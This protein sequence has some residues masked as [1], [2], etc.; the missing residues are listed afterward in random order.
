V[1]STY[2]IN[3]VSKRSGFTPATL[4]YYEELGLLPAPSRT[5]AGYRLYDDRALERLAFIARAKQLGCS[6]DETADLV[7][8]WEGGECGPIQDRLRSLVAEKLSAAQTQIVE[9]MTL[10]TELQTAAAALEGHRPQGPCDDECGCETVSVDDGGRRPVM[11]STKPA[12]VAVVAPIECSLTANS[13]RRQLDDWNALFGWNGE[14]RK[15]VATR[16]GVNGGVRLEF[17]PGIDVRELARLATAEQECCRFFSFNLT[18]DHRGTGLEVRA[19]ADGMA[20]L[21]ALF[22]AST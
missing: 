18:V 7:V 16:V 1:T 3:E 21:H 15:Q 20:V 19:P 8:A 2:K 22:G 12:K 9:L 10:T 4:R 13:M 17:A 6:L 11:L 14:L 5:D